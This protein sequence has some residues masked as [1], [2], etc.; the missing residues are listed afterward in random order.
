MNDVL[1]KNS[2]GICPNDFNGSYTGRYI[3]KE[4]TLFV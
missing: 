2:V 1:S 3:D 4:E